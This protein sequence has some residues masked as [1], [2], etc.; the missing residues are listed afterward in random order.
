M[1]SVCGYYRGR[2]VL[3]IEGKAAKKE[4]KEKRKKET[5]AKEEG[6]KEESKGEKK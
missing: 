4:K 1:C 3:D 2:K 5:R 6:K